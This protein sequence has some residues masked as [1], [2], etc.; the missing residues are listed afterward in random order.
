[1]TWE[2]EIRPRTRDEIREMDRIA[3]EEYGIPG[4]ILMEN[5]G[6][7]A[8]LVAMEMADPGDGPVVIL[9]GRGN[10]GGDG[11]VVARHLFNHGYR[12]RL[13]VTGDPA[14]VDPLTDAG[15]NLDLAS[16]LGLAVEPYADELDSDLSAH[17]GAAALIVDALLGTGAHGTVRAPYDRLIRLANASGR[18]ILAIDIPSG[19]DADTGKPGDP[20]IQAARTV[21]FAA[22]KI[23][24]AKAAA[25]TGPVT[26]VEISIPRQLYPEL[27]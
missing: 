14:A 18:P 19:L 12:V 7:G 22:P 13:W 2:T 6:R 16:T 20:C 17:L 9:C 27:S 3:I 5:A 10:N 8:A 23:G 1:M 26:V 21:T 15:L 11:F 25:Q 4:I 24:F